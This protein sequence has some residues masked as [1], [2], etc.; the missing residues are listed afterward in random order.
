L[1]VNSV[2][3]NVGSLAQARRA[4]GHRIEHGLKISRRGGDHA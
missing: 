3:E 4:L 2:D 1:T